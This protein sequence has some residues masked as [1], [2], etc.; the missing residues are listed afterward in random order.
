MLKK[1]ILEFLNRPIWG[2]LEEMESLSTKKNAIE[3][4]N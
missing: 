3:K 2:S 4:C 1:H